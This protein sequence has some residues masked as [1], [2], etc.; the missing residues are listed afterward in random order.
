MEEYKRYNSDY[1]QKQDRELFN[2]KREN[3][4]LKLRIQELEKTNEEYMEVIRHHM[5]KMRESKPAISYNQE[6]SWIKKM[7]YIIHEADKPLQ[8]NQIS[9]R[10]HEID[11]YT[12]NWMY[13]SNKIFCTHLLRAIKTK[14]LTRHK[15]TGNGGY[16]YCLPEWMDG[17]TLGENYLKKILF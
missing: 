7:A 5:K 14:R 9:D 2:L 10:L 15:I 8:I 16:F 13:A 12:S 4:K 6:W 3:E 1:P 17:D 11:H